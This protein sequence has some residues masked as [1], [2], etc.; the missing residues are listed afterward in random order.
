MD[1]LCLVW[2]KNE[3]QKTRIDLSVYELDKGSLR[4]TKSQEI[5]SY[6]YLELLGKIVIPLGLIPLNLHMV[7]RECKGELIVSGEKISIL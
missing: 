5:S 4:E 6:L 7:I 2:V 3:N 1:K